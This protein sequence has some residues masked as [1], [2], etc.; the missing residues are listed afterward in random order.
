MSENYEP[1]VGSLHNF[2]PS[3]ISG[4]HPDSII[5]TLFFY[6]IICI[7]IE[8][9]NHY[10]VAYILQT[11]CFYYYYYHLNILLIFQTIKI[12]KLGMS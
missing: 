1:V 7:N 3:V 4:R 11:I 10:W 8:H 2:P 5:F 9:Q 12:K 6:Y